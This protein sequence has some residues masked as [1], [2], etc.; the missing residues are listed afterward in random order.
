MLWLLRYSRLK[1]RLFG[2]FWGGRLACLD[3]S[4]TTYI[5]VNSLLWFLKVL[6]KLK[7]SE[8]PAYRRLF[9]RNA[10]TTTK[11]K[12]YFIKLVNRTIKYTLLYNFK[13]IAA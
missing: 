13:Y 8:P 3:S 6:R 4:L 10:F 12:S 1:F 9:Y 5:T 2:V 7:L 11:N